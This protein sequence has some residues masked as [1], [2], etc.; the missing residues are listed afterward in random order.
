MNLGRLLVSLAYCVLIKAM[1][2]CVLELFLSSRAG[3]I[4]VTSILIHIK[5]LC[6]FYTIVLFLKKKTSFIVIILP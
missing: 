3:I 5:R 6:C 2:M 4:K 1:K